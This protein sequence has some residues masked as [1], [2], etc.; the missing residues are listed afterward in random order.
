M[1][2][3]T[4]LSHASRRA[5]LAYD[6]AILIAVI[7]AGIGGFTLA[8]IP[9]GTMFTGTAT[10]ISNQMFSI[11]IANR[12][13]RNRYQMWPQEAGDGTWAGNVAVLATKQAMKYP[14]NAMSDFKPV[15]DLPFDATRDGLVVRHNFGNGGRILQRPV[16]GI[17]G[18]YLE[19]V[20]ENVPLYDA[21]K[22]DETVDG[23][24]DADNGRVRLVF[25]DGKVDILYR[26]NRL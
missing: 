21:R 24:Q 25:E 10:Q 4:F 5:G 13:F 1:N 15:L 2:F 14:Y 3:W 20:Y 22:V 6:E 19:V 16:Q 26:A 17:D 7:G 9:W 18:Q 23:T 11:E 8:V 12:E